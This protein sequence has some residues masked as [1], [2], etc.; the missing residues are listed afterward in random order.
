[1]QK[2]GKEFLNLTIIKVQTRV[3]NGWQM[4]KKMFVP[5]ALEAFARLFT[6]LYINFEFK[7]TKNI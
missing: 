3:A 6:Y 2:L 1:M 4:L 7:N 5:K